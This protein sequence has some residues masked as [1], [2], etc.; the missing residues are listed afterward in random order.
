MEL[1][2]ET[3]DK[4]M[5]SVRVPST[6]TVADVKAN[7]QKVTELRIDQQMLHFHGEQLVDLQRLEECGVSSD[8]VIQLTERPGMK[9]GFF[10]FYK[11]QFLKS[12]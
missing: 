2:V 3:P 11:H 4:S 9:W 5:V 1:Q 12:A 8:D 10:I 7:I 6:A